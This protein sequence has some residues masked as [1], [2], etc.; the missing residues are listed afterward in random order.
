[1]GKPAFCIV[2]IEALVLGAWV[3]T[4]LGQQKSGRADKGQQSESQAS[5]D[6]KN[7]YSPMTGLPKWMSIAAYA[8]FGYHTTQ[9]YTPDYDATIFQGDSR[10]EFWIP[11]GRGT[12]SW[13]PYIRLAGIDGDRPEAWENAW[14]DDGPDGVERHLIDRLDAGY[15]IGKWMNPTGYLLGFLMDLTDSGRADKSWLNLS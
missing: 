3:T 11:P 13:G 5:E 7:A 4:V 14:L 2:A 15:G 12:F 6:G 9:F 8:D 1:M 10:L